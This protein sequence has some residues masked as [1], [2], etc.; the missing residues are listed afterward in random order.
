[1]RALTAAELMS[2]WERGLGQPSHERALTLLTTA[3]PESSRDELAALS[4]GERDARLLTLR[5][6]TFGPE[7]LGLMNCPACGNRLELSLDLAVIRI[8]GGEVTQTATLSLVLQDYD[9]RFRLPDSSDLA[10]LASLL[11]AADGEKLLLKRCLLS[12][13]HGDK[14]VSVE[15]LPV[16]IIEA[17]AAQMD[18]ADPQAD[19]ELNP[20]C[21]HCGHRWQSAFD[22]ESFFWNEIQ[23]WAARTMREV[24]TLARAYGWREADILN[25]SP[26]RRRF[27]LEMLSA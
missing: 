20:Q 16:E 4:I 24:H 23:A 6:W 8:E 12:S 27:Y 21:A 5:E 17:I 2:V 25:I 10:A 7:I 14:D 26:Q 18:G 15:E 19:V 1:M 13:R 9:M 3:C 11:N 22:I